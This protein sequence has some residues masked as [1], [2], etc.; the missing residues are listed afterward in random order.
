MNILFFTSFK[1][2]PTKG[3]TERTT[4]SVATGLKEMYDFHCYS[5]YI[6]D[7]DT[8]KEECFD[9][10]F[11]L[12]GKEMINEFRK[13]IID[14]GIDF[15]V[16]QGDFGL[17]K[18]L[19]EN[20][21]DL[22][23]KIIIAHHFQPGWET[24]FMT[25]D[26]FVDDWKKS[27]SI[28]RCFKRTLKLILYPALRINFLHKLPTSY[29][30]AYSY[31]DAVVLLSK[32]F[33]SPFMKYGHINDNRKFHIIPNSIS[34]QKFLP[35]EKIQSKGKI[36]LI[37]SRL[38][39]PQKRL[40]LAIR[41]WNTV[42]KS[43][44]SDGWKLNI[45]GHGP[46]LHSY[47]KLISKL[48]IPDIYLLG[49]QT[50]DK[51]YEESSIFMMTSKSEGWGL[52]LTEAQ[53]MG[54]VPIAFNSYESLCDIINNNENGI[55]IPECDVR[56]YAEKL[57]WLMSHTAERRKLAEQAIDSSH[58]YENDKVVSLWYK[59]FKQLKEENQTS[60]ITINPNT[61]PI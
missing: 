52:T 22:K 21:S 47:Q 10:E 42:K 3:G 23:C 61:P 8:P 17:I 20:T 11:R 48:G 9:A 2:S 14:K 53:Q 56:Q 18:R 54:V 7:A 44:E 37:V 4:I 60:C 33:I 43:R 1:V 5:A 41:I 26:G 39:D 55:V 57:L 30:E 38:D 49:R 32:G 13:V 25:F 50:P 16:D 24:H 29:N 40:S 51:F 46:Y 35:K 45:V 28:L 27:P 59:L 19:K 34:F 36:A 31:A 12:D 15:V 6:V 58:R